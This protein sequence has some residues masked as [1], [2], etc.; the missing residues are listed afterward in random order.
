MKIFEKFC[1]YFGYISAVVLV[2][3]MLQVVVNVITRKALHLP[4]TG[5]QELV[6]FSMVLVV[7]LALAWAAAEDKHIKVD[8]IM[9]HLPK[10]FQFVVDTI[11]L[12]LALGTYA[13]ITY[14]SFLES[15]QTYMIT[16]T[17][18]IPHA[19]F[20]WIM[21]GALALL[22]LAVLYRIIIRLSGRDKA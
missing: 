12:F 4:I 16:S 5:T 6:E 14:F 18:K 20:H 9:E 17:I 7:F 1:R 21:S 2:I 3:M 19:P 10:K 8:L 13:V 22:T 15:A 11:T